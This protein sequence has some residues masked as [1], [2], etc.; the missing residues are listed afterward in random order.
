MAYF[1]IDLGHVCLSERSATDVNESENEIFDMILIAVWSSTDLLS[2]AESLNV[3]EFS[4]TNFIEAS[5]ARFRGC[6]CR[7]K[8]DFNCL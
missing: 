6:S 1:K 3:S 2:A 5:Y 7:R 8:K 4:L